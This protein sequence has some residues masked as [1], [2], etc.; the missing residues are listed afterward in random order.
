MQVNQCLETYTSFSFNDIVF[1]LYYHGFE[2]YIY[3]VHHR[4]K[5]NQMLTTQ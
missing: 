2:I 5:H 1:G 4:M 3:F